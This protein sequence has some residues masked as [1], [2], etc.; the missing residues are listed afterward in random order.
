MMLGDW[1]LPRVHNTGFFAFGSS[2]L[3]WMFLGRLVALEQWLGRDSG[4]R[5]GGEV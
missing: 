4:Y 2:A 3:A 5:K 1:F